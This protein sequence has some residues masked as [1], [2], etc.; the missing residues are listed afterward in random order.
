M[1]I[2][3][4]FDRLL[5]Q[6]TGKAKPVAPVAEAFFRGRFGM[7]VLNFIDRVRERTTRLFPEKAGA[8]IDRR[9]FPRRIYMQDGHL[10]FPN[11]P[12][13]P[14]TICLIRDISSTGAQVELTVPI[15]SEMFSG[16]IRLHIMNKRHERECEIS[17]RHDGRIGFRF[18]GGRF[19]ATRDYRHPTQR[20]SPL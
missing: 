16:K 17:W 19:P 12:A 15:P 18:V 7:Q 11:W 9:L 10:W 8:I 5:S 4:Q 2:L 1:P 13:Y 20:G 3:A 6:F 14:A